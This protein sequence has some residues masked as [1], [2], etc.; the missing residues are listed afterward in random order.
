IEV[1][2]EFVGIN[3]GEKFSSFSQFSDKIKQVQDD[4]FVQ[5]YLR[6]SRTID[7]AKQRMPN[8]AAKANR[9]LKYYSVQFTCIFGGKLHKSES[10]G[11]RVTAAQ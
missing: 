4:S 3:V 5:L 1:S 9:N 10:K 2:K 7:G 6:D 8:I 11:A